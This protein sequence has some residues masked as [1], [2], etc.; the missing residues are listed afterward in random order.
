MYFLVVCQVISFWL[1]LYLRRLIQESNCFACIQ[2]SSPHVRQSGLR[3]PRNF[4]SW[5]L[6]SRALESG[7][8]LSKTT[9]L[10]SFFFKLCNSLNFRR[11]LRSQTSAKQDKWN[12]K[13]SVHI[14]T[15]VQAGTPQQRAPLTAGPRHR[16]LKNV[17]TTILSKHN[18]WCSFLNY[19][20][21]YGS[22][23]QIWK[24]QSHQGCRK[25]Q[26]LVCNNRK[27]QL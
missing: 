7:I 5:N 20:Q 9:M 16:S 3:N 23:I 17:K 11:R 26:E 25:R 15:G 13:K 14:F 6:E 21:R 22:S 8:P 27:G 18:R 12:Y 19:G 1:I 10:C 4:C 2:I 24:S